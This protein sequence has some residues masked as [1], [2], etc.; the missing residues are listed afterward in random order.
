[1]VVYRKWFE[2]KERIGMKGYYVGEGYMGWV[3]GEYMLFADEAD[4]QEYMEEWACI[5]RFG[6]FWKEW[7]SLKILKY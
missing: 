7:K 4:Y 5:E 2:R 1:M 6:A 3:N